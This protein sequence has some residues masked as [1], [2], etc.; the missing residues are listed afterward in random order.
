MTVRTLTDPPYEPVS[1]TQAKLWCKVTATADDT[2]IDMLIK[3][4]R[5][6]AENLTGRTFVQRTLQLILT[7]YQYLEIDGTR[8]IGIELPYPPLISVESVTYID[9]DGAT[10]TLATTEYNVHTWREPGIVIEDWDVTWPSYR[11]EPDAIRVN[12]T[13]GYAPSGSPTDETAYQLDLPANLKLWMQA[14]IATLY[15]N[16]EQVVANNAIQIPRDFADGLLDSL[17]VGTRIF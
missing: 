10:Q 15:D 13:A 8:R 14:R 16:R 7:G 17:I 6:Y 1:R 5:E 12:Y 4:M 3:G 11:R 2:L 9:T